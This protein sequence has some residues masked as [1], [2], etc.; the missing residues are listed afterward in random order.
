MKIT[1]YLVIFF[2]TMFSNVAIA[3]YCTSDTRFTELDYFTANEISSIED[4]TFA[5]NVTDGLGITQDLDFDIYFPSATS[6]TLAERPFVLLLHGGGFQSGNRS[7]M[8]DYCIEFV[9]KGFVAATM[10]YR[11]G[12]DTS[13]PVD[14]VR[15]GYRV[16][17]DVYAA[18]R[19]IVEHA[20]VVD[21][22][23]S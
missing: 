22:D 17:Q 20:A 14:Q 6:E 2:I 12:W 1:S 3:Q 9:K 5:T 16:Q 13:I 4:V 18:L 7:L 21:I 15:A 11:K 23:T 10:D 19:Y 8:T